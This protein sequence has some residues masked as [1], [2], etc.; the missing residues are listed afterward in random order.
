MPEWAGAGGGRVERGHGRTRAERD[1]RPSGRGRA[2]RGW[3]WGEWTV[4]S[5]CAVRR[6]HPKHPKEPVTVA[7]VRGALETFREI[8][9]ERGV[10][11]LDVLTAEWVAH[12]LVSF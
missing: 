10:Q 11:K 9:A 6:V 4:E 12:D 7:V 1:R 8:E 3:G 5:G 2:Q